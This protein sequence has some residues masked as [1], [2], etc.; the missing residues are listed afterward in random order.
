MAKPMNAKL[1]FLLV[2]AGVLVVVAVLWAGLTTALAWAFHWGAA[3]LI[4]L[5]VIVV[6]GWTANGLLLWR[7][8]RRERSRFH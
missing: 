2:G 7:Q 3:P 1:R 5:V 4:A 8:T 6:A